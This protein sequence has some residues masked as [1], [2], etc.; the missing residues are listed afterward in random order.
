MGIHAKGLA[1]VVFATPDFGSGASIAC[2]WLLV[3]AAVLVFVVVGIARGVAL[4]QSESHV[5]RRR[6]LI[7]LLGSASVPLFCCL[8]PPCGIRIVYG[9]YPLMSR[10]DG[11][12][13]EGMSTDEVTAALGTPHERFKEKDGESWYYWIDS[14]GINS[15]RVSFGPDG[16]VTDTWSN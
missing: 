9:N 2:L 1:L 15:F 13:K 16:R 6:G 12:V 8:A 11:K 14:M 5:V 7:L 4:L 3:W 10:P